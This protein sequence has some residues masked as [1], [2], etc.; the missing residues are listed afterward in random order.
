[1]PLTPAYKW[2]QDDTSCTVSI[3]LPSSAA[4]ARNT[5]VECTCAM[6]K[7]TCPPYFLQVGK[8]IL[9]VPDAL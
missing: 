3:S 2:T 5:R 4:A 1:M 7:L 8:P 9:V 6:I